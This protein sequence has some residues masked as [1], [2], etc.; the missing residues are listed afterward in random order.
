V[1]KVGLT[2]GIATGKSYVVSR[3][4]AAGIPVVDADVL[5]REAVARGSAG[6]AAVVERFG[7]DVL[8]AS[9]DLDRASLGR[10]VFSDEAARRDLEA[11]VHPFV[12]R[13]IA[14]FFE[15]L[16]AN[17][18]LAVADI[19]LLFETHQERRFDKVVVVACARETQIERVMS[20]DGLSRDEAERRVAAQL[21][22]EE[23]VRR[24]DH[25]V[26]TDGA[27]AETDAQVAAVIERLRSV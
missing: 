15:R 3:L 2:G 4:R 26:R 14:E 16:P 18:P 10:L 24:A 13:G 23:K 22:L 27:H 7:R 19:P 12:R 6:L 8:T 5:A 20:R 21:P 11:I 17:V 9:G 25:V 1:I